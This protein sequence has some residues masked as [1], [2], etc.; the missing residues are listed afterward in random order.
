MTEAE[1]QIALDG[2]TIA[3]TITGKTGGSTKSEPS[4]TGRL[5]PLNTRMVFNDDQDLREMRWPLSGCKK[6]G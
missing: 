6:G 4:D 5:P 2:E 3:A 1:D